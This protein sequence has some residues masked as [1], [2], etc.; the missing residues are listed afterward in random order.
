[1]VALDLSA[2]LSINDREMKSESGFS[3]AIASQTF[4]SKSFRVFI[5]SWLKWQLFHR[6]Y[7]TIWSYGWGPFK[8]GWFKH[9]MTQC[10]I[11]L[12]YQSHCVFL[13]IPILALQHWMTIPKF[14]PKPIPRLFLLYHIFRNRNRDFFRD[15]IFPKP[16]P[17]LFFRDQ[18]FRNRNPQK[19]GKSL[20][21]ET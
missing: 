5:F 17:R 12:T 6:S 15:Q 14:W 3:L 21:T 11:K 2:F 9:Y 13:N 20:E 1:M 8:I 7:D 10:N 16:K 19:F 4:W 18:I